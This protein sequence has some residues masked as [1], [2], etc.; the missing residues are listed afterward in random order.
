MYAPGRL[1]GWLTEGEPVM[2]LAIP[3]AIRST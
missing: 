1:A 3:L 2:T